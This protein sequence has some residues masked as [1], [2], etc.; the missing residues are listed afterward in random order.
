MDKKNMPDVSFS[1]KFEHVGSLLEVE[2][3]SK[4]TVLITR[5]KTDEKGIQYHSLS[6][7]DR[8]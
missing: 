6:L 5:S 8:P 2:P 7:V 3:N 4:G 1:F